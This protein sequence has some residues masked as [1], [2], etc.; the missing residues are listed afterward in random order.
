M[1]RGLRAAL[2]IL[3]ALVALAAAGA[4]TGAPAAT[5]IA[6]VIVMSDPAPAYDE[7]MSALRETLER[8]MPDTRPSV[9]D[10]QNLSTLGPRQAV[11]TIGTQAARAVAESNYR[12]PVL[13]ALVPHSGFEWLGSGRRGQVSAIFIDQPAERQ[14]ALIREALPDWRRVALLAGPASAATAQSLSQ[15]AREQRLQPMTE[16]ARSDEGLYAALQKLLA[17]P[18]VL[19]A[20][21]DPNVFN[22]YTIQNILLTAYR[23][24]SP[25]IGYSPAY[26]RAGAV[27]AIYSTP[28]QIGIHAAEIL[29]AQLAGASLP[30]PQ[31]CRYFEVAT[32]P[33]VARSLGITL[34]SA[35]GI[36][37][38]LLNNAE[39]ER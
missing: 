14:I 25:V 29:S 10:W 20:T 35:E 27:L 38:R 2:R 32:N 4:S 31:S 37:D 23:Q 12:G 22:S 7:A 26:V 21:P 28:R 1:L 15:A 19:V 18:A 13:H 30:A 24:R 5:P 34:E 33:H 17:E 3:L 16:Q 6:A 11:V 39:A 8:L 36:R 9:I